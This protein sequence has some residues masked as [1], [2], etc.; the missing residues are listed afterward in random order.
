MAVVAQK[1]AA[2]AG[3]KRR[4]GL[5]LAACGAHTNSRWE[6]S[7]SLAFHPPLDKS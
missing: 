3:R 7:S 5:F 6:A 4:S 1:Q 2:G